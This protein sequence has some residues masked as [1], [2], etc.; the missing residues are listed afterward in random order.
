MSNN[1]NYLISETS[2]NITLKLSSSNQNPTD[3]FS[4]FQKEHPEYAVVSI[5]GYEKKFDPETKKS[6]YSYTFS[7]Q[8]NPSVMPEQTIIFSSIPKILERA[9]ERAQAIFKPRN[10]Q[11]SFVPIK[12]IK[13][14]DPRIGLLVVEK[15]EF[16]KEYR[17]N[18]VSPNQQIKDFLK[19]QPNMRLIG[20]AKPKIGK[21]L[22]SGKSDVYQ[23]VYSLTAIYASTEDFPVLKNIESQEIY[24]YTDL[25][26]SSIDSKIEG[27]LNKIN[28]PFPNGTTP[29]NE[30]ALRVN[31]GEVYIA[32]CDYSKS[33][34]DD[35]TSV[36]GFRPEDIVVIN[37]YRSP[38]PN[39]I[40]NKEG[41][42]V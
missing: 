8:K 30:I 39:P 23:R 27:C 16:R 25:P 3:V 11:Y 19:E 37:K 5:D 17:N 40:Q 21:N 6:V 26:G 14:S 28:K 41:R 42:G 7:L 38:K 22:V 34:T 24:S 31:L 20:F 18:V 9:A 12:V 35:A 36:I 2:D 33:D 15:K 32:Q 29:K 1:S 10:G 4:Q 13:P